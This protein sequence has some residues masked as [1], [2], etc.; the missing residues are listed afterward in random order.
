[1]TERHLAELLDEAV[2]P[3]PHGLAI[4]PYT[5]IRHLARRRR[6]VSAGAAAGGVATLAIALVVALGGVPSAGPDEV[7]PGGDPSPSAGWTPPA[8]SPIVDEFS[9]QLRI[10]T[11]LPRTGPLAEPGRAMFAGADLAIRDINDA[12]GVWGGEVV[13]SHADSGEGSSTA[14]A[15]QAAQRLID[16]GVRAVIGPA[17]SAESLNIMGLLAEA[18]V[19]QVSPSATS[20]TLTTD[21]NAGYFFRTVP[22]EEAEA[23]TL[24]D[25]VL[26]DGLDRVAILGRDDPYGRYLVEQTKQALER[27]GAEVVLDLLHDADTD[28]AAQAAAVATADPDAIVLATYGEMLQLAPALIAAGVGPATRWWYFGQGPLVSYEDS[29]PDGTLMGVQGVAPGAEA[30]PDFQAGLSTV[31]PNLDDYLYAPEA[32][33]ATI[34][35]ALAAIAANTDDP[36][37]IRDAMFGVSRDGTKCTTFADC[38]ALLL[39]GADIDY[40]GA[41]GPIEWGQAGDVTAASYG[42]YRYGYYGRPMLVARTLTEL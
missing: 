42:I 9:G 27:G 28:F 32:Y 1:M 29:L 19:V 18:K 8:V 21:A 20:A 40:D 5:R 22:S 26:A 24:A 30:L 12:G 41:S 35:V 17:S 16:D 25:R 15:A 10:G 2:P 6:A 4:A 38:K 36:E 34:L 39:A 33:D 13:V 14:S 3:I 7:Q 31:D 23:R 37:Q 11:L